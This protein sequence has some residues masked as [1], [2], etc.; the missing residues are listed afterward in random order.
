MKEAAIPTPVPVSE[1]PRVYL[2]ESVLNTL[3][4]LESLKKDLDI[5]PDQAMNIHKTSLGFQRSGSC[6]YQ[7]CQR[8]GL[9][10]NFDGLGFTCVAIIACFANLLSE[11]ARLSRAYIPL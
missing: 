9:K 1:K 2:I 6:S 7:R 11:Y 8:R 4:I 10:T 5:K 3:E